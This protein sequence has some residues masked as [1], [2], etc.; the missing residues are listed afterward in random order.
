MK[1]LWAPW[2]KK[3]VT[4]QK[5]MRCI[6]CVACR[7]PRKNDGKKLVVCRS[8]HGFIL[9]NLYPHNNGHVMVVPN[10]HVPSLERLTDAERLDLL[11]LVDRS[12]AILKKTLH[13]QGFNIG[14]NLGYI[15]GAGFP[16]HLHIHVVPRWQGDTNFMPI[17]TG[18]KVISNSLQDV[19]KILS[20]ALKASQKK[21][22]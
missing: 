12:L 16:N 11:R 15:G 17:L 14:M 19:Y 13:P 3:Y 2:R 7:A 8:H 18:T 9:L 21:R 20:G 10:R 4:H 5:P 6:F 22:R 1:R